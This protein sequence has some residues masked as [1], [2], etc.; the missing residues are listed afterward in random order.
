VK[1]KMPPLVSVTN[2]KLSVAATM[3]PQFMTVYHDNQKS[4]GVYIEE[5][6][7]APRPANSKLLKRQSKRDEHKNV[8]VRRLR[9]GLLSIIATS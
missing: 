4:V 7:L 2:L 6:Y 3:R 9:L 1:A 5:T 8:V